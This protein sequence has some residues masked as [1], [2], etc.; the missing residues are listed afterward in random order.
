VVSSRIAGSGSVANAFAAEM[1]APR[2]LVKEHLKGVREVDSFA[3]SEIAARFG[4]PAKCVRHQI[5]NYD[6]AAISDAD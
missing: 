1:L 2:D 3:I 4:A 6:L 5:E